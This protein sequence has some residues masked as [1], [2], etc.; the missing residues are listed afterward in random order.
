MSISSKCDI[1][2]LPSWTP[3][4]AT[5]S[6]LKGRLF[7]VYVATM[8]WWLSP[9]LLI[10]ACND[11][12]EGCEAGEGAGEGAPCYFQPMTSSPLETFPL[13]AYL[14]PSLWCADLHTRWNKCFPKG[15]Q[16][17]ELLRC[18]PAWC[19]EPAAAAAA[20]FG[21]CHAHKRSYTNTAFW[22]ERAPLGNVS[23]CP[24]SYDK[25]YHAPFS[26]Y[27]TTRCLVISPCFPRAHAA[28]PKSSIWTAVKGLY[29]CKVLR[30]LC[31]LRSLIFS[32]T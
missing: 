27:F 22:V 5:N 15:T 30:R 14:S 8:V 32:E 6:L 20:C 4:L 25:C 7:R 19:E 13:H 18:S 24:V 21:L 12:Q 3:T 28:W 17:L 9:L 10:T 16:Q 2:S 1:P 29:L 26:C 23:R 11:S 31:V